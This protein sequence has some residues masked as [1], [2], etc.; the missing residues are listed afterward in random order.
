[1]PLSKLSPTGIF[2]SKNKDISSFWIWTWLP[3]PSVAI[4][5]LF[6]IALCAQASNAVQFILVVPKGLESPETR[7]LHP[8]RLVPVAAWTRFKSRGRAMLVL[9]VLGCPGHIGVGRP[10]WRVAVASGSGLWWCETRGVGLMDDP[11]SSATNCRKGNARVIRAWKF[12]KKMDWRLRLEI[13][14]LYEHI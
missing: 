2:S 9:A 14:H 6:L 13:I 10:E 1:M 4:S 5:L 7:I 11:S 3:Y 12:I 8:T